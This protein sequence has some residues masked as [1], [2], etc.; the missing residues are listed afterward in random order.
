[1]HVSAHLLQVL[2]HSTY[3]TRHKA[4]LPSRGRKCAHPVA[5]Q[6]EDDAA[7]GAAGQAGAHQALHQLPAHPPA[8]ELRQHRHVHYGGRKRAVRHSP[9]SPSRDMLS[10][11]CFVLEV[12][13]ARTRAPPPTAP[14]H[15]AKPTSSLGGPSVPGKEAKAAT[16]AN[17]CFRARAMRSGGMAPSLLASAQSTDTCAALQALAKIYFKGGVGRDV[18]CAPLQAK[19]SLHQKQILYPAGCPDFAA[20]PKRTSELQL[21][22]SLSSASWSA[23]CTCTA[24]A[25]ARPA[26]CIV[27]SL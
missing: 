16:T 21:G 19:A 4:W 5:R 17:V 7:G 25:G 20:F 6:R 15:L 26:S 23:A 10:A 24:P 13:S 12:L 8:P 22:L 9:G 3:T 14:A 18:R 11:C 2:V 1:M 27:N